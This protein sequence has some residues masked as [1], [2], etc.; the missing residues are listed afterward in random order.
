MKRISDFLLKIFGVG[1]L[2]ALFSGTAAFCGYAI[3]LLIGGSIATELSLFIYGKFFP[4]VIRVC[5]VAVG[6]GLVGMYLSKI[7]ALSLSTE[8]T[9][10]NK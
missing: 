8:D 10:E 3:A 9:D 1:V 2:F 7:K 5:S 4:M 6:V